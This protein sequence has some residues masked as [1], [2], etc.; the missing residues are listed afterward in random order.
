[1][2]A[3]LPISSGF[4]DQEIMS[5]Q[6]GKILPLAPSRKV[7]RF[8]IVPTSKTLETPLGNLQED[9]EKPAQQLYQWSFNQPKPTC[10]LSPSPPDAKLRLYSL[11]ALYD[12]KQWFQI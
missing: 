9:A 3:V 12:G 1:M 2:N 8:K 10:N 4:D 5:Q 6:Q 7:P 11:A